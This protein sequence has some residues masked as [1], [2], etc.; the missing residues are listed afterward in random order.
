[1]ATYDALRTHSVA[2]KSEQRH[3]QAEPAT[4]YSQKRGASS[5]YGR[6][7]RCSSG[8]PPL[9][10]GL[11]RGQFES[12]LPVLLHLR[13]VCSRRGK[14]QPFGPSQHDAP[15]GPSRAKGTLRHELGR[16]EEVSP[17]LRSESTTR[18][19][20]WHAQ[21]GRARDLGHELLSAAVATLVLPPLAH[22]PRRA[23]ETGEPELQ[24]S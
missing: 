22:L 15:G 4:S 11:R 5:Q 12:H 3:Q 19:R 23:W 10:E 20:C 18:S 6:I 8:V 2:E 21:N 1:M 16:R 14:R 9:A 13:R 17:L 24:P 7:E